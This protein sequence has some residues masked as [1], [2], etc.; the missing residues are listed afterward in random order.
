MTR[1]AL[2]VRHVAGRAGNLFAHVAAVF[3]GCVCMVVGLA[4]SVTLVMLPAGLPIGLLGVALVVSG[5]FAEF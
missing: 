1:Q 5:L 2:V 3:I 4:L